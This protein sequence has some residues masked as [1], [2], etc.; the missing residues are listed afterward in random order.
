MDARKIKTLKHKKGVN[1]ST[2]T[3]VGGAPAPQGEASLLSMNLPQGQASLL[4][5]NPV[6]PPSSLLRQGSTHSSRS[7]TKIARP[8]QECSGNGK[9]RSQRWGI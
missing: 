4:D 6:V 5:L 8:R 3:Q 7:S 1:S 2:F 9:V